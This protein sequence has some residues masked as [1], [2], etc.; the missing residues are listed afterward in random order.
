MGFNA[1]PDVQPFVD[2]ILVG[3]CLEELKKLPPKSV[4]LVFADPPYNLQLT[5]ELTGPTRAG[6]TASTTHGT[7]LRLSPN[8]TPSPATGSPCA[9]G[10]SRTPAACG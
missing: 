1:R 4:D 10:R 3:D 7:A 5:G 8:M 9:G 6:S 2:R